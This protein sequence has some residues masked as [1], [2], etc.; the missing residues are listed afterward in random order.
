MER[1][2]KKELEVA[3]RLLAQKEEE[4]IVLTALLDD[5]LVQIEGAKGDS[6]EESQK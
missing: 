1:N 4:V 6:A 2:Y 5:A 3:L